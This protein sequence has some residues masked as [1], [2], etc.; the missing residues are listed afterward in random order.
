MVVFLSFISSRLLALR[1]IRRKGRRVSRPESGF[2]AESGLDRPSAAERSAQGLGDP[3][4]FD[5]ISGLNLS[6]ACR[7]LQIEDGP[8]LRI[9]GIVT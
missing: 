5:R 1:G 3:L 8:R 9:S 7:P 4:A 6:G 2:L